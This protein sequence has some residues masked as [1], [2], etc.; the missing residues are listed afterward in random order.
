ME[1][2]NHEHIWLAHIFA[3]ANK[4][5]PK[6]IA[7]NPS[8][9]VHFWAAA[10]KRSGFN[11]SY[12]DESGHYGLFA[13][14]KAIFDE[15]RHRFNWSKKVS[16]FDPFANIVAAVGYLR[17]LCDRYEQFVPDTDERVKC[18]FLALDAGYFR[19]KFALE[20]CLLPATFQQVK[21]LT[22]L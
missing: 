1:L 5:F 11:P 3:E 17:W 16:P 4:L 15:M 20:K 13:I 19:V 2:T 22:S 12:S 8:F 21:A 14:S 18:A 10:K 6:E 7:E 9:S